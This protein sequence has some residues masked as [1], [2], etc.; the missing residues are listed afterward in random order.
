MAMR[1]FTEQALTEFA[2]KYPSSKTAL[3]VWSKIVRRY[4]W[5][6]FHDMKKTFGNVDCLGD[7]RYGFYIRGEEYRLVADVR[8]SLGFVYICFIGTSQEYLN[9]TRRNL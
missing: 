7:Q 9:Y 1:I 3:Q 8:F 2:E 4:D 6:N 5:K